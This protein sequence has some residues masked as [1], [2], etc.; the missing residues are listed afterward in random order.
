M[1]PLNRTV[2]RAT[3]E[4]LRA[5]GMT[6][7]FGNPGSN[8]LPFLQNFPEDFRYILAI[9]EGAGLAMADGYAQASGKPVLV[10]L[11]SAS[12]VGQAMGNL[13]NSAAAG[14]PLVIMSGQQARP[15]LTME[16]MLTNRDATTLPRPLVKWSFEAPSP[17]SV[18]AVM[19]RAIACA[20]TAP[21]GPVYV[22][23]PLSDWS[24]PAD[25]VNQHFL[26]DRQIAG[27]PQASDIALAE[28]ARR[29]D[30]AHHPV[31]VL[32]PDVD[33]RRGWDDAVAL[34]EKAGL[35]VIFGSD[36]YHRISFP[37]DHPCYRGTLGKTVEQVREQLAPFDLI[38]WIGGPALPYHAWTPGGYL[39]PRT[40][41]TLVTADPD[42]AA[43][44]P[45]GDAI[46]GDPADALAR[47]AGL[48]TTDRPLPQRVSHDGTDSAGFDEDRIARILARERPAEAAWASEAPSMGAWWDTIP[49]DRPN[50]YFYAAASG[51]GYGLPAA[52]GVALAQPDRPVI[53]L[54]GDGAANYSI[55][56]LW[57]AAQ[58]HLDITFVIIRNGTYQVLVDFGSFL[59]TPDLPGLTLPDIDFVSVAAGY[60]VPGES[61]SD[62]DAFTAALRRCFT[63][64]GPHLIQAEID[65][66]P[67][68]M[69]A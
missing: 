5:H 44:A 67:S 52:I 47:L 16:G 53:A 29:L 39:P 64:P 69:F 26:V 3:H 31:L 37:T 68:G 40:T 63:T 58:H 61:V 23:V 45:M 32:G 46:I 34:A 13:V 62:A 8:E 20:T 57:T 19:A 24:E 35:P 14:T 28:L 54:I 12:G 2:R 22:S 30:A 50:S 36:E 65:A 11:H 7:F 4:V 41:L 33:A 10:S 56:G 49:I 59:K 42:Q 25:A 66:A 1:T 60:G 15:L 6:T 38:A 55:T 51:L 27:H 9:H 18:P 43:R 17:Q 21:T 48:V